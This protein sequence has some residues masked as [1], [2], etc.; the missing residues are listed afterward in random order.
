MG[1]AR[2]YY[3]LIVRDGRSNTMWGVQFGDYDIEGVEAEQ[4]EYRE[5][6]YRRSDLTI[7]VTDGKQESIVDAMNGK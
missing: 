2:P 4:D 3:S 6:G 7:I 1:K 5:K